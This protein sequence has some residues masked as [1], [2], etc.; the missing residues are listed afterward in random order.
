MRGGAVVDLD[1]GICQGP[2]Q[3]V[4][5]FRD[6]GQCL[7]EGRFGG[8]AGALM[9]QPIIM[10]GK[11]RGG[12]FLPRRKAAN[13]IGALDFGLDSIELADEV[14]TFLGN[15]RRASACDFDQFAMGVAQ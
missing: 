7:T 10:A 14:H 9:A 13:S 15:W 11:D 5:V 4:A 1:A 12:A 8:S 2:T 3:A 6:I